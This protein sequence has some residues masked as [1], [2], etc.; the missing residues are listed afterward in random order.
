MGEAKKRGSFEQRKAEAAR[1]EAER[2]QKRQQE[3]DLQNKLLAEQRANETLEERQKRKKAN[4]KL[5]TLAVAG[6]LA[7]IMR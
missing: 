3:I 4:S 1:I 6:M 2:H 7:S 5:A